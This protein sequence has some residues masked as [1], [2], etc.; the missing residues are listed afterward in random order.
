MEGAR[1]ALECVEG[2]EGSVWGRRFAGGLERRWG[3]G[4]WCGLEGGVLGG[5]L[6]GAFREEGGWVVVEF[7]S[8]GEEG[9]R[10]QVQLYAWLLERLGECVVEG[11][12]VRLGECV[13]VECVEVGGGEAEA[14]WR[15][16]VCGR[17]EL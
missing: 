3:W 6:D 4:V 14:A 2:W 9:G 17:E 15:G 10:L 13:E 11:W 7:K 8:G 16:L 12:V 1:R 5:E